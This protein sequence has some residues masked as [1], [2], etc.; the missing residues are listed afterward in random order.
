M[1][2]PAKR[3]EPPIKAKI[4]AAPT[5]ERIKALDTVIVRSFQRIVD[6]GTSGSGEGAIHI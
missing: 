2:P 5:A 4:R 1:A 6:A 3:G